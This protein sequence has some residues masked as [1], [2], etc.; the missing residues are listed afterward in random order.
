MRLRRRV[1]V[2]IIILFLPINGPLWRMLMDSMGAPIPMGEFQ[3]LVFSLLM[4]VIGILMVFVPR[5]K[6]AT[7][8]QIP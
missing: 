3:F 7:S 6:F 8:N 5:I 1:G 4:F 2:I